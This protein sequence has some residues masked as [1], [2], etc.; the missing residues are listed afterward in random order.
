[1][2]PNNS[3]NN[4]IN[5]DLIVSSHRQKVLSLNLALDLWSSRVRNKDLSTK[6]KSRQSLS[7]SL[8]WQSIQIPENI[9]VQQAYLSASLQAF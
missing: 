8:K 6:N 2:L 3:R 5:H 7:S 1:M 4:L 9:G